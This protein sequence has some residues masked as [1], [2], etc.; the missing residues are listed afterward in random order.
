MRVEDGVQL[1]HRFVVITQPFYPAVIFTL[2]SLFA[3][4]VIFKYQIFKLYHLNVEIKARC[5][6]A[7]YMRSWLLK[8]NADFI[9][10][11]HQIDTYFNTPNGRLKL[12]QGNIENTLIHY[13]RSNQAGP[14]S[15]HVTMTAVQHGDGLKAVLEVAYGIMNVVDKQREIYFINNVKFH[16]DTVQGLGNFAEIEA[17][18]KDGTIGKNKLQEQCEYYMQELHISPDDLLTNS[19]SDMGKFEGLNT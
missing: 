1:S 14:K 6:D 4:A 3:V 10:T 5:T 19:Y 12:R 7:A 9:G 11:D 18:D 2:R 13:Q 8:N 17:I 16:I 15:S